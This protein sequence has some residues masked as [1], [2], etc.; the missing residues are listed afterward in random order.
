M[1]RHR[2]E[3]KDCTL[4]YYNLKEVEKTKMKQQDMGK[5][6]L[7]WKDKTRKG[8]CPGRQV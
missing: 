4:G 6:K 3:E 1:K 7:R 2:E 8:K 5:E